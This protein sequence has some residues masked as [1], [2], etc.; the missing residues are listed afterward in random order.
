MR[1]SSRSETISPEY[2]RDPVK[3]PLLS[4]GRLGGMKRLEWPAR[5]PA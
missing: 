2:L 4:G 5:I 3:L 1:P